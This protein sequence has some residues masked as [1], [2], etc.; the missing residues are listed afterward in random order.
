MKKPISEAEAL[1]LKAIDLAEIG[2]ADQAI[3]Y[4]Q[5]AIDLEP[6]NGIIRYN[7]GLVYIK[8]SCLNEAIGE[9]K[10]AIKY[11]PED[12]NSY[13]ALATCY[14]C[15]GIVPMTAIY[16]LAYL[17]FETTSEKAITVKA[18][19]YQLGS[20]GIK[21]PIQKYM[22][23]AKEDFETRLEG[24]QKPIRDKLEKKATPDI[25]AKA[26][27]ALSK[28]LGQEFSHLHFRIAEEFYEKEKLRAAIVHIICGLGIRPSRQY[29]IT[30]LAACYAELGEYNQAEEVM[31]LI[32]IDKAEPDE[33]QMIKDQC[34]H[35]KK[36]IQS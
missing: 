30:L 4:L 1:Y 2:K 14:F 32:E 15:K 18:R 16:Y 3:T 9:F 13:F 12:A 36:Y 5:K 17:D 6:E 11:E 31:K 22:D 23:I 10:E 33:I 24:F 29:P 7:L 27:E 28:A 34:E 21:F 25:V 8:N 35:L 19:L 20:E 26:M